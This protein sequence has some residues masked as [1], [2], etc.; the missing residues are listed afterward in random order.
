MSDEAGD[1]PLWSKLLFWISYAPLTLLLLLFL[2]VVM[3]A[4]YVKIAW[5]HVRR[6]AGWTDPDDRPPPRGWTAPQQPRKPGW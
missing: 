3:A 4:K 1:K 2:G 6:R 5:W